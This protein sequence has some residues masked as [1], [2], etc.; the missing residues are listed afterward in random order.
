MRYGI[1]CGTAHKARVMGLHGA[2]Q[3]GYDKPV[4]RIEQYPTELVQAAKAL[5]MH[6]KQLL[7]ELAIIK[8]T[9]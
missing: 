4:K 9:K 3:K 2:T 1:Q 6:P 8:S 7:K 5:C